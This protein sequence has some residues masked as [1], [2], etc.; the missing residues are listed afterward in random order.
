MIHDAAMLVCALAGNVKAI[1]HMFIINFI[2][3]LQEAYDW[4]IIINCAR[5]PQQR[6]KQ[7]INTPSRLMISHFSKCN[8]DMI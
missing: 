3:Q 6:S 8:D 4:I 7:Y 1:A 2:N 5:S